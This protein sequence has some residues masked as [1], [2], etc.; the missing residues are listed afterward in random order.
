MTTQLDIKF[1]HENLHIPVRWI[2]I[3]R[4]EILKIMWNSA[5]IRLRNLISTLLSGPVRGGRLLLGPRDGQ[6]Q[7]FRQCFGSGSA[8]RF[9][10]YPDLH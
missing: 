2:T 8:F 4:Y 1:F 6:S 5:N 3:L 9:L 10:L 7:R